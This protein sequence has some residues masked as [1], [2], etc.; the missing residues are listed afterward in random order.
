MDPTPRSLLL[1]LLS[2]LRGRSAPV[3]ALV[4]AAALFGIGENRLRVTLARL[5]AEGRL[6]RDERGRYRLG[7]A[8]AA[9]S[10]RIHSWRGMEESV[11]PWTGAW[12]A[13]HTRGL[14]GTAASRR[15]GR[16]LRLLGLRSLCPG[17]EIRPDNLE[18]GAA[19]V[20]DRLRALGLEDEAPVG[21]LSQLDGESQAR[22]CRLW[23]AAALR[24]GYR[25]GLARLE[26]SAA[27][28][29]A[30]PRDAA[31]VES[32]LVGGSVL[33]QLVLDPRLPDALVPSG[34]RRALVEAM[35]DYDRLG[36]EAWAGWLGDETDPS[37]RAP[38]GIRA[39]GPEAELLT[40]AEGVH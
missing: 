35:R 6:E 21:R 20:G 33:R 12:V 39:A 15:R 31:R 32:F 19:A 34:D 5:L 16:A 28:L 10:E 14:R 40:A 24:R 22:A 26:A 4:R 3:R 25:A 27:R 29:C 18:G 38:A 17:L 11:A 30:L 36:R 37:E 1:D 2:T 23:D 9:V 8:T 7:P 13:V